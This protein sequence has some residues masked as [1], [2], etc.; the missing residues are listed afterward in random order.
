M[1]NCSRTSISVK[2]CSFDT[3]YLTDFTNV[4]FLK[5]PKLRWVLKLRMVL[6]LGHKAHRINIILTIHSEKSPTGNVL[7][8]QGIFRRI[9]DL[10]TRIIFILMMI[11]CCYPMPLPSWRTNPMKGTFCLLTRFIIWLITLVKIK[12]ATVVIGSHADKWS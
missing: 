8:F 9:P 2:E 5:L 1:A 4:Q 6:W 12:N 3:D 11:I 7:N 10:K